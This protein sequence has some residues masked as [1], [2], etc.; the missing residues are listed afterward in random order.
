MTASLAHAA[1]FALAHH[2][3]TLEVTG[4][5]LRVQHMVTAS[6]SCYVHGHS[7]VFLT[8]TRGSNPMIKI[9]H[10]H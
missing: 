8:H 9:R 7:S 3:V 10:C 1:R 2:V 4:L 5:I 6:L